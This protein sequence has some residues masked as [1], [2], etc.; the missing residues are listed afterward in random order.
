MATYIAVM[1][2]VQ[3]CAK[4]PGLAQFQLPHQPYNYLEKVSCSAAEQSH[5]KHTPFPVKQPCC[6]MTCNFL[7]TISVALPR[8]SIHF[9]G[10]SLHVANRKLQNGCS[11]R[12]DTHHHGNPS[13]F[14]VYHAEL[15]AV[16][17]LINTVVLLLLLHSYAIE[18][19][20]VCTGALLS[21]GRRTQD[22]EHKCRVDVT[23]A[24][25]TL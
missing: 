24:D 23:H 17:K 5:A 25:Y 22:S 11:V 6:S 14:P 10:E 19:Q 13:P 8:S 16:F 12:A 4:L 18:A 15:D 3:G 2:C 21:R 1:V 7:M 9:V 20:T